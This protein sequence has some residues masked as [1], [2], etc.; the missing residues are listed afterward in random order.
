[1]G[2]RRRR[3][4]KRDIGSDRVWGSVEVL[5]FPGWDE[6]EDNEDGKGI[7]ETEGKGRVREGID[8]GWMAPLRHKV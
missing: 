7:G 5:R 6:E 1:L 8:D 2:S 4:C 3:R